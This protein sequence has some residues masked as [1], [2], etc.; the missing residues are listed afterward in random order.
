MRR[1]CGRCRWRRRRFES[2]PQVR[3]GLPGSGGRAA[4]R[5]LA[6]FSP[7]ALLL[8]A[9]LF[10]P[11]TAL[12]QIPTQE[13]EYYHT[14][15]LGSVRAV[16]KQV[17]GEWQ[18]V[19]RHDFMPA[20]ARQPRRRAT[21]GLA[22]AP[23]VSGGAKAGRLAKRSRRRVPPRSSASISARNAILRRHRF[24][25]TH[26]STATDRGA[27]TPLTSCNYCRTVCS[28]RNCGTAMRTAE[29]TRFGGSTQRGYGAR[30][31]TGS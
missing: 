15:A 25:W 26:D 28:G 31:S 24:I 20:S 19:A 9:M 5:A 7:T 3:R 21:V 8:A 29:T 12:A 4:S 17:N 30:T 11:A 14:D 23:H 2:E 1:R 6:R 16:T 13:V 18:V 10:V 22:V 27:S